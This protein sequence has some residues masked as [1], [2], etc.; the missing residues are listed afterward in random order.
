MDINNCQQ[1]VTIIKDVITAG[2]ALVA[3]YIGWQGLATWRKQLKGRTEYELARRLL[4]AIYKIRNYVSYFRNPFMSAGEIYQSMEREGIK[5]EFTDKDYSFKS[6]SAVYKVRWEKISD[7]MT[8][9]EVNSIEAE[10]LWGSD[11][12]E[13]LTHL[14]RLISDLNFNVGWYLR[15]LSGAR[16]GRTEDIERYERYVFSSANPEEDE[17]A[18]EMANAIKAIDEILRPYLKI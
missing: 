1:Y 11:I 6:S 16:A 13:A 10:V 5:A 8:D 4:S 7:G 3:A 2:A 14:P 12:M 17:F 15:E 9:L 18:L